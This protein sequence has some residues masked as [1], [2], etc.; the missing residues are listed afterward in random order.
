MH[1]F[2]VVVKKNEVGLQK[3]WNLVS[4]EV[5][6]LVPRHR[7]SA[8]DDLWSRWDARYGGEKMTTL[9]RHIE[10]SMSDKQKVV[11]DLFSGTGSATRP[12]R[13]DSE[14]YV[15]AV[16]IE[17]VGLEGADA[18]YQMDIFDFWNYV[19]DGKLAKDLDADLDWNKWEIVFV[20]ASPDCKRFSMA[21][22]STMGNH[23]YHGNPMSS[24][25]FTALR[26]VASAIQIIE[27]FDPVYWAL[28]NPVG[29]LRTMPLMGLHQRRTVTYCQYDDPHR[30]MKP[31][32][33]WGILPV[34]W[35]PKSCKAGDKCHEAAPRGSRSG[36]QELTYAEKIS[37]P[38]KLIQSIK[39]HCELQNWYR[40]RWKVLSD[41]VR[42][43]ENR[44]F[45]SPGPDQGAINQIPRSKRGGY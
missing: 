23:W 5:D 10:D 37:I 44:D 2:V 41:Y 27:H 29:L 28:E 26:N 17:D 25:A 40:L 15:I 11:I 22:G 1:P 31:T 8:E 12:Y 24:E 21:G 4:D 13:Q 20:W 3:M 9:P 38:E 6:R 35:K 34:T 36:T 43:Q 33:I 42:D 7:R 19:R 16:D 39:D 45:P 14:Y 18:F 32:D 30:R